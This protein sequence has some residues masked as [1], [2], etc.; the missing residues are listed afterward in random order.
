MVEAPSTGVEPSPGPIPATQPT[1]ST[2]AASKSVLSPEI[3][4]ERTRRDLGCPGCKFLLVASVDAKT[5]HVTD[6]WYSK[7]QLDLV[8]HH[9]EEVKTGKRVAKFVFTKHRENAD[10]ILFWTVA[11][12][13]RPYV[14]YVPH[15]ETSTANVSGNYNSYGASGA[16]YGNF[17]G[18]VTVNRT[19][20]QAQNGQWPY[21]DAVLTVYD[22]SGKKI[23]E[24]WH[25]GN[26]RWSKPD[27]DCLEDAFKYLRALEP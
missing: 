15:T 14:T 19:Y 21:I 20:Y 5:G 10:Y 18:T 25:Q 2:A 7:N 8:K 24:T 17:N 27:K 22:R 26:F 3:A 1:S 6:D 13:F 12:G 23:Y 16:D 11:Q 4:A 9:I